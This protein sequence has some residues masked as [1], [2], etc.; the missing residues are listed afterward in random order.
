MRIIVTG[1]RKWTDLKKIRLVIMEAY[2]R[3]RQRNEV[4]YVRHGDNKKGA[5]NMAKGVVYRCHSLGLYNIIEEPY[6]ADWETYG[7]RAGAIR[8]QYMLDDKPP[9]DEVHAFPL[10]DSRGTVDM[11][12]RATA[13]YIPLFNHGWEP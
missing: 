1:S 3:A 13:H 6:P 12:K 10:E 2:S 11:M 5:D 4:L 8:N 9:V 7:L